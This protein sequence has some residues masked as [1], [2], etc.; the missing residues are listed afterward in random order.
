MR[1]TKILMV[2]SLGAMACLSGC[3]SPYGDVLDCP[4][5]KNGIKCQ[6]I[7]HVANNVERDL[8]SVPKSNNNII[9]VRG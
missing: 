4:V 6:S 9:Y 2:L 1:V 5:P 3:V 8:T 7:S